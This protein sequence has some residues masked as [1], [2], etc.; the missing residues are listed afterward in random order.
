MRFR[1]RKPRRF[2]I[3]RRMAATVVTATALL[4]LVAA[5]PASAGSGPD[6][7]YDFATPDGRCHGLVDTGIDRNGHHISTMRVVNKCRYAQMY[8]MYR[9]GSGNLQT[10]YATASTSE[11]GR[12]GGNFEVDVRLDADVI[13]VWTYLV[14]DEGS[15]AW[16]W[17]P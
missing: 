16:A 5:S 14:S 6:A 10:T 17:T 15:H 13:R 2:G 11:I 9:D 7:S 8:V 4:T 12:P 3:V 1:Q